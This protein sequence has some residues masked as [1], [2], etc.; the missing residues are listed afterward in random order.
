M[1]GR[2]IKSED[3]ARG[4]LMNT[5]AKLFAEHGFEAVSTRMLAREAGVNIAMISYYFGSKEKLFEAIIE[6]RIPKTREMLLGILESDITPWEK[7]EKVVNAYADKIF[8]GHG[9][10]KLIHRELSLQQRPAHSEMILNNIMAN[11]GI[12]GK[13][14]EEGQDKGLFRK[15]IDILMTLTSTFGTIGHVVNTP[16]VLAKALNKENDSDIFSEEVKMRVKSHL[17][18][19]LKSHLLVNPA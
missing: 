4:A 5:A 15:D 7:L 6:E 3:D 17:L 13:I 19:M 9:F 16:C 2:R 12:V 11:W 10:S 1:F 18:Q 8:Q 14:I